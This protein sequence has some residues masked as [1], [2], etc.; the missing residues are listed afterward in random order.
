MKEKVIIIG[1][2]FGGI[3]AALALRKADI[4]L[5]VID[6]TNHHL[7]QPL[8]YQVATAAISTSNIAMP[9]REILRKQ[10]NTSVLMDDVLAIDK[11]NST[12][13][14]LESGI[15][16]YDCLVVAAGAITSYYG[17]HDWKAFAP[18]LKT[19]SDAV[20]I[21]EHILFSFELAERSKS[22]EEANRHLRFVV[23]GGGPTGVEMAGAIAEIAS[24]SMFE[25]FKKIKPEHTRIY[26]IEGSDSILSTYP[27]KLR[28]KATNDLEKMG[29]KVLTNTM[30]TNMEP[31]GV[32][33][34]DLLIET[35]NVFW[36]GGNEA[37]ALLRTLKVPL[38]RQGRVIVEPDLSLE[39]YP[40]I[41]VIGDAAAVKDQQFGTLPALAPVAMQQG[42]YV[43]KVIAENIPKDKRT[44]FKYFDKGSMTTIG[45][46]KA[47]A[48]IGK[49][50]FSGIFAWLV[51]GFVHIMYL[52]SFRNRFLVMAQWMFLYF[53]DKRN[54]C[55]II[56]SIDEIEN[57]SDKK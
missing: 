29:I 5:L 19:L 32:Y 6:K 57:V 46:A 4:E 39:G 16:S 56:H 49:L 27:E 55:D 25:N 24:T 26:L 36:T 44:P 22:Q 31:E 42:K 41:F 21:R 1:G 28:I 35:S 43:A 23:I 53:T 54:A 47:V 2:G 10:N 15:L 30:V 37:S 17:H 20:K 9:I 50:C 12:I 18:G 13:T 45:K 48:T 8:L 7:F 11:E 38:D 14:L 34:G 51:W 33:M 52:I 40:Q 3:K